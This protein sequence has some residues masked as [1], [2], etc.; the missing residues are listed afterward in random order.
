MNIKQKIYL[1]SGLFVI[2]IV[3]I[4][5]GLVKPLIKEIEKASVS[6]RDN[7]DRLL[8]LERTDKDYLKQIEVDYEDVNTN[9]AVVK[10]GLIDKDQAVSFFMALE[11]AAF[12]SSNKIEI[13]ATEFPTLTL[14][15]GGTFPNLMR[16]VGWLENGKYFLDIDSMEI[17]Q[18]T[19]RDITEGFSAEYV[20]TNLEIKAY[21]KK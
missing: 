10:S 9:L 2:V 1:T 15:I 17:R 14:D 21:T 13:K 4:F 18:M 5:L 7:R 11:D 3:F 6:A 16:F 12:L 20:K 8:I 19:E